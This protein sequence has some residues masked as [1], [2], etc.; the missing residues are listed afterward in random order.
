MKRFAH[1]RNQY[2]V[3]GLQ[4]LSDQ[5]YTKYFF[6]DRVHLGKKGWV[7]VDESLYNYYK[8]A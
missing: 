7:M 5:E 1:W 6:E 2:G 4:T 3:Q 8:E